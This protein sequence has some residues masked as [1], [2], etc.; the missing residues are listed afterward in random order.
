MSLRGR[1]RI[2]RQT[3]HITDPRT[4]NVTSKTAPTKATA[5]LSEYIP[6]GYPLNPCGRTGLS[7]KGLLPHWGP[8]HCIIIA[9]TRPDPGH[10]FYENLPFIQVGLLHNNQQLCLPWYLT[11][12]RED[13]DFQDCSA[14]VIRG[15]IQRRLMNLFENKHHQQSMLISLRAASV[16]IAYTGYITDHL[17][18]DHAWIEG[19]LFNIHEN[20]EHPFQQE[21]LQV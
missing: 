16:S 3:D 1:V 15:F 14:N 4:T 7:G 8:N 17:N 19:V 2:V 21:F 12:H 18:A 9:I 6:V 10:R 20:E 13:C 5:K 11:D